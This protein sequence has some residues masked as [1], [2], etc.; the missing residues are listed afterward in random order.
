MYKNSVTILA[1]GNG[2]NH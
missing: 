2:R 1:I